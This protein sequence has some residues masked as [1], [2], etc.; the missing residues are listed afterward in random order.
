MATGNPDG[1]RASEN[2]P[3]A[4]LINR[5]TYSLSYNKSTGIAN[6]CSWQ[7]SSA[8]K[9]SAARYSGNFIPDQT[10]P[11]DWYQVKHS[12]YTNTSFDR[13]HRSGGPAL[14]FG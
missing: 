5:A 1:A 12:D 4:Y 14:P 2:S 13:G 3:N 11:T 6:W 8:W 10:L 7:L 9:G